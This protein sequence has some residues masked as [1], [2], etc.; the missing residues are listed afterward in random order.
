M[1]TVGSGVGVEVGIGEGVAVKVALGVTVLP[2][3][4]TDGKG[5]EGKEQPKSA[6]TIQSPSRKRLIF[7]PF[8]YW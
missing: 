2:S 7:I 6:V 8:L 1:R 3:G 4:R 5:P